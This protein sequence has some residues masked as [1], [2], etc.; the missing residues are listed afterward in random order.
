[1]G[2]R[3]DGRRRGALAA[4]QPLHHASGR[5]GLAA[6]HLDHAGRGRRIAEVV[7]PMARRSSSIRSARATPSPRAWKAFPASR[8]PRPRRSSRWTWRAV[9]CKPLS[10]GPGLKT[11]PQYLAERHGRVSGQSGDARTLRGQA[12]LIRTAREDHAASC[13]VR[14]GRRTARASCTTSVDLTNRAQYTPAV[15]L[16]QDAGVSIHGRVSGLCPKS[17]KLAHH[18]PGFPLRQSDRLDQ[19]HEPGRHGPQEGVSA[20]GWRIPGTDLVARLPVGRLRIRRVLR[21]AR[22]RSRQPVDGQGG[23]FREQADHPA[24]ASMSGFPPGA[25]MARRSSIGPGEMPRARRPAGC[26]RSS[27][28]TSPS[29]C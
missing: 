6:P 20:A 12:S 25:R 9:R 14:P 27:W 4:H 28:P 10:T 22:I 8:S 5:H 24:A 17:G 2:R 7:A 21:R 15:Q 13:A 23:R 29:P 3:R 18:G 1:M 16:G 26:G 19:R 11:N